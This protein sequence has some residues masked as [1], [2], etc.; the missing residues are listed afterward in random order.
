[1]PI[2]VISAGSED[3]DKIEALDAATVLT[4]AVTLVRMIRDKEKK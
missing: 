1:M 3:D 4:N 2:I